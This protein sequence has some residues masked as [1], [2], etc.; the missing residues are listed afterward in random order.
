MKYVKIFNFFDSVSLD[1]IPC[2]SYE[3]M[4]KDEQSLKE[5]AQT[6]EESYKIKYT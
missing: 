4:P 6:R 1:A 2:I 3:P 5:N